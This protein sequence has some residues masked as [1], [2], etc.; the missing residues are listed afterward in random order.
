MMLPSGNDAATVL[1]ENFGA[2]LYEKVD[3]Y[4]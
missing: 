2:F 1:G 4:N 3:I